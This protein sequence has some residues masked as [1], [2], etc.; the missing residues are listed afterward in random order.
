MG[1]FEDARQEETLRAHIRNLLYD[2][3]TQHITTNY[4]DFTEKAVNE[5]L[6]QCLCPVPLSDNFSVRLPEE[7]FDAL[8]RFYALDTDLEPYDEKPTN[9][10]AA[11]TY[12]RNFLATLKGKSASQRAI[13]GD[14]HKPFTLDEPFIPILSRRARRETPRPGSNAFRASLDVSH[15]AFLN[16]SKVSINKPVLNPAIEEPAVNLESVLNVTFSLGPAIVPQVKNLLKA[17]AALSRPGPNYKNRWLDPSARLD[18]PPLHLGLGFSPEF[19]PI[20]SRRRRFGFVSGSGQVGAEGEARKINGAE[21]TTLEDNP[22]KQILDFD[23]ASVDELAGTRMADVLYPVLSGPPPR[24]CAQLP[25]IAKLLPVKIEDEEMDLRNESMKIVDG[26]ETYHSSSPAP[27]ASTSSITTPHSSQEEIDQL[28]DYSKMRGLRVSS[29][30]TELMTPVR[31][32]K[33]SRMDLPALPRSKRFESGRVNNTTKP[34]RIGANKSLAAFLLDAFNTNNKPKPKPSSPPKA[35][36]SPASSPI[37]QFDEDEDDGTGTKTKMKTDEVKISESEEGEVD[38]ESLESLIPQSGSN[39]GINGSPTAGTIQPSDPVSFEQ[40]IY[41]I[42]EGVRD[43]KEA[44]TPLGFVMQEKLV[45]ADGREMF[46]EVPN[47]PPPNEHPPDKILFLPKRL[48]DY[49]VPPGSGSGGSSCTGTYHRFLK[50]TKG[51]QSATLQLSWVPF[52][53]LDPLPTDE[54]VVGV[55]HDYITNNTSVLNA[56]DRM[57][58]TLEQGIARV[59]SLVDQV[60]AGELV[61]MGDEEEIEKAKSQYQSQP[62]SPLSSDAEEKIWTEWSKKADDVISRVLHAREEEDRKRSGIMLSREER[63]RLMGLGGVGTSRDEIVVPAGREVEVD[64]DT[65]PEEEGADAG[66]ETGNDFEEQS[67]AFASAP[68]SPAFAANTNPNSNADMNPSFTSA[69]IGDTVSH[70]PETRFGDP[71]YFA[72]GDSHTNDIDNTTTWDQPASAPAPGDEFID[73]MPSVGYP[74]QEGYENRFESGYGYEY[75]Y[76]PGEDGGGDSDKENRDPLLALDSGL[77]PEG[78]EDDQFGQGH[79]N[80]DSSGYSYSHSYSPSL[81]LYP[82]PWSLAS[83]HAHQNASDEGEEEED[84]YRRTKRPRLE[85]EWG[86]RS[87]RASVGCRDESHGYHHQDS[88]DDSGIGFMDCDYLSVSP[89]RHVAGFDWGGASASDKDVLEHHVTDVAGG[90]SLEDHDWSCLDAGEHIPGPWVTPNHFGEAPFVPLSLDSQV[91]L[92]ATTDTTMSQNNKMLPSPSPSDVPPSSNTKPFDIPFHDHSAGIALFSKLRAKKLR[93]PEPIPKPLMEIPVAPDAHPS[94][95]TLKSKSAPETIFDKDTLRLSEPREET[96]TLRTAAP[97]HWYMA[98]VNILQKQALVRSFRKESCNINLV[99]R[100]TLTDVDLIIDPH[101]A[102]IFTNLFALPS[103][104]G[105]VTDN[106]SAQSWRYDHLLVVFEAFVPSMAFKPSKCE[107]SANAEESL[108]AYSPPVLKAVGKFR[109]GV[110]LAEACGHK[111]AGCR[112]MTAFADSVREAAGLVRK[113]GDEAEVRD[114]TGGILWGDRAWLEDDVEGESNLA[115]VDG[116]NPFAACVILCQ[117][118]IDDLVEIGPEE[119]I[120][121]FAPHVGRDRMVKLNEVIEQRMQ[122]MQEDAGSS[123]VQ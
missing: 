90:T 43:D 21:R 75:G 7:P 31:L 69:S 52:T 47:L 101:T 53:S 82:R 32:L 91:V 102:I 41:A 100:D 48:S 13:D 121:R 18:S 29:P 120:V 12:I 60:R 19:V 17:T 68:P 6:S 1:I 49:I 113:F 72:R 117:T 84:Q 96:S 24:S 42:L 38:I 61:L 88:V 54:A 45:M 58:V 50:K 56:F 51:R 78:L 25:V 97:A 71:F 86:T 108:S 103:A 11:I 118:L 76:A 27:G 16:S 112:V 35:R 10:A 14:N 105:I 73:L 9:S 20:F 30:D 57:G 46:M 85:L 65:D 62:G 36:V 8:A 92:P 89:T 37:M 111:R 2:Y 4:V 94:T 93:T 83:A 3:A 66:V 23:A 122:D 44:N 119:R 81:A 87:E 123:V 107:S 26:W 106:V 28:N 40:D 34:K 39:A 99:E 64:M 74:Y 22:A 95:T 110:A 77:F 70:R 63:R 79:P 104:V 116:M 33:D 98:S 67:H 114:G 80:I 59:V 55:E 109:R 5:L 115:A 15:V